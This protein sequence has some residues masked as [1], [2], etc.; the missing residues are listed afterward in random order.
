MRTAGPT[1]GLGARLGV[2]SRCSGFI[3]GLRESMEGLRGPIGNLVGSIPSR[4]GPGA[5]GAYTCSG[6]R[7]FA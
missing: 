4:L 2:H 3:E 6:S 5:L 7:C 1:P